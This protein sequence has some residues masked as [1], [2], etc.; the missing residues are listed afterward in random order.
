MTIPKTVSKMPRTHLAGGATLSEAEILAQ[1]P[2]AR[3]RSAEAVR[4]GLRAR[5]ARY[6]LAHETLFLTLTNGTVIGMRAA[7][8]PA[9]RQ[10][11]GR[12]R[13]AVEVTPTGTALHWE[14]LDV[15][16][17]VSALIREALG[18]SAVRS[19]F[20]AEGGRSTSDKKAAAARANGAKGG[21][22]RRTG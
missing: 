18:V 11:T 1:I 10:A 17:S 5:S 16:L 7:G 13:A 2:A 21:R 22:P 19:L 6:S 12:Q 14:A 9:L 20:A 15:D 3:T 4:S 8:I